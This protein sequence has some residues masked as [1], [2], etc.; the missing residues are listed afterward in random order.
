MTAASI[1]YWE[2]FEVGVRY[3]TRMRLIND[4]DHGVVVFRDHVYNQ[5]DEEVFRSDK[6]ALPRRRTG[7]AP[8][9]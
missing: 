2:D 8:G 3:P 9:P 6:I 5:R 7:A 1:L 4:A